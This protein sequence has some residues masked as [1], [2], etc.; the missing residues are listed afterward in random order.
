M[1]YLARKIG[2][3]LA[4]SWCS[5]LA[6]AGSY[7]G[8]K[9]DTYDPSTGLYFR[10]VAGETEKGSGILGL[11]SKSG[12]NYVGVSNIFVF[13]PATGKGRHVFPVDPKRQIVAVLM[14]AGVKDDKMVFAV[15]SGAVKNN[16]GIAIRSPKS[17]IL[18]VTRDN[19]TKRDT[20]HFAQKDG[21]A[22][23]QGES[24]AI[25]DDWHVDVKN[26]MV[27]VVRQREQSIQVES[28][29]WQ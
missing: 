8:G 18:I 14:E 5:A 10:T 9:L 6:F 2:V 23:V 7:Y 1:F 11:G 12:T 29:S 15:D 16:Q 20:F 21:S 4:L 19:E 22:L 24:I 27:R 28:F 26:S 3:A 17:S 13:D 25:A